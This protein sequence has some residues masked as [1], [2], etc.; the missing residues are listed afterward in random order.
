MSFSS[1]IIVC[2][3]VILSGCLEISSQETLSTNE[4]VRF[5]DRCPVT[6]PTTRQQTNGFAST[7]RLT[8]WNLHKFQRTNWQKE[9]SLLAQQSDLLLFQESMERATLNRLLQQANFNWQQV[10]AFRLEGEATGVLSAAPVAPLYNC[11][12][13]DL[14]PVSRIPKS[15]LLTLYPLAGSNYPLLVI[16]VH[17]INFELAMAAYYHQMGR[18]FLLA[19]N[20]PGPAILAGDF[21]SWGDKRTQYLLN[22][23]KQNGFDEAIATPDLRVQ[24]MSEPV[25]HIFYRK[26][27]LKHASS[28]AVNSSDHNPLWAEFSLLKTLTH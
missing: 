14:E 16:N 6:V 23:A 26:L 25:D 18:I 13:R 2:L 24:I 21:A 11:A 5:V 15:A 20:Y 9:V 7:F 17:G 1:L 8:T 4:G 19:K 3:A 22:L 10:Q 12:L 27:E 28:K